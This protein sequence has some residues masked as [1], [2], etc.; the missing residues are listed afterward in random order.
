MAVLNSDLL[1]HGTEVLQ[2]VSVLHELQDEY[3][4]LPDGHA[5]EHVHH[6]LAQ[7]VVLRGYL[8][9]HLDLLEEVGLF[10]A[11]GIVWWGE[12]EERMEDKSNIATLYQQLVW[13]LIQFMIEIL[14]I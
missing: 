7:L 4:R 2:Q 13:N 14:E 10:H 11:R 5:P 3:H 1:S 9:H 8:L 6:K 12:N